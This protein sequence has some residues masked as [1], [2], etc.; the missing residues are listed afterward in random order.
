MK[1]TLSIL[2]YLLFV[3]SLIYTTF[4]H[5]PKFGEY[6]S[7]NSKLKA[8]IGYYNIAEVTKALVINDFII[9]LTPSERRLNSNK[10]LALEIDYQQWLIITFAECAIFLAPAIFLYKSSKKEAK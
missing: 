10:T 4:F 7:G 6:T 1:K 3:I 9:E 8:A 2:L 5:V